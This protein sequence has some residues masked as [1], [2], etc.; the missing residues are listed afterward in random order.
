MIN[1]ASLENCKKLYELSGWH[2]TF[3]F[4]EQ[5][6]EIPLG[7]PYLV[8]PKLMERYGL[9]GTQEVKISTP[10]YEAG[11]LL[12]KVRKGSVSVISLKDT[13]SAKQIWGATSVVAEAWFYA[14]ADTP[15]DAL[16]LLAI[17][18]FEEGTLT[19]QTNLTKG[20]RIKECKR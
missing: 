1:V 15:E 17:K 9:W 14:T 20:E 19:G 5:T 7:K 12:R 2:D 11:Y 16:C 4:W 10:A 18:L 3:N 8:Q 13:Y 6:D